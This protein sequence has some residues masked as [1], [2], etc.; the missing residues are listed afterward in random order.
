MT[1]VFVSYSDQDEA[2]GTCVISALQKARFDVS[3]SSSIEDWQDIAL[4]ES[5]TA[6]CVV[7]VWSKAAAQSKGMQQSVQQAIQAWSSGRLVLATLDGAELPIGLRDLRPVPI[8][9]PGEHGLEEL[10]K[11]VRASL[12]THTRL[13]EPS[14]LTPPRQAA[15][16]AGR[17]L[18]WI[19]ASITATVV[20]AAGWL[21][22]EAYRH[23]A[24]APVRGLE[25]ASNQFV[26]VLVLI[27]LGVAI[28][29]GATWLLSHKLT[30]RSKS[31]LASGAAS[32]AAGTV[33]I[34]SQVFVSYSR[35]DARAVDK[36]VHRIEE[37]GYAVWIDREA[38]GSQRY[39][40]PIVR[41]IKGAGLVALMGSRNAFASDHVIR[42]VY[43]AGD[44]K[45]PF[46]VFQLDQSEF[47]DEVLYFISGFPRVSVRALDPKRLQAEISRLLASRDAAH[48]LSAPL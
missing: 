9:A 39:A 13:A 43:V 33:S 18:Q 17:R 27:I 28:G 16:P 15:R 48:A 7:M 3:G 20:P 35:I 45:K 14:P 31:A 30:D 22:Y 12:E 29:A 41:A 32:R 34:G 6:S 44:H 8:S 1:E 26:P 37:A 4:G 40:A 24:A 38:G 47:P 10:V 36:L 21:A 25:P 23:F 2:T 5:G 11:A 46:I 42:E 19:A